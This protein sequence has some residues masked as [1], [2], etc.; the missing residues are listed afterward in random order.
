MDTVRCHFACRTWGPYLDALPLTESVKV[1]PA[2]ICVKAT[3]VVDRGVAGLLRM[4]LPEMP[5][6]PYPVPADLKMAAKGTEASPATPWQ[7]RATDS[8][9]RTSSRSDGPCWAPRGMG[10]ATTT[11]CVLCSTRGRCLCY[12]GS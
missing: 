6:I 7:R 3:F 5:L 9:N 12:M 4:M 10:S 2:P 8:S 1:V 11:P